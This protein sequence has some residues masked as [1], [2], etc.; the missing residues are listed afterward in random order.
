MLRLREFKQFA[1]GYVFSHRGNW[2]SKL[3]WTLPHPPLQ[4]KKKMPIPSMTRR[5]FGKKQGRWNVKEA[6]CERREGKHEDRVFC[7]NKS[8]SKEKVI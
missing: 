8:R 7:K 2:Y 1:L 5:W 6:L 3:S 4:K